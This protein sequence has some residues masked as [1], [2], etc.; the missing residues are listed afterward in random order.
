[1]FMLCV[2]NY[3]FLVIFI[4][5]YNETIV[6]REEGWKIE[7][8]VWAIAFI[9]INVVGVKIFFR[10]PLVTLTEKISLKKAKG[11]EK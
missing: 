2:L 10:E 8:S 1:M 4:S 7:L 5:C 9:A 11:D 6:Y 3:V